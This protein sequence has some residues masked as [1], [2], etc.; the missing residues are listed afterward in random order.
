VAALVLLTACGSGAA[1]GPAG[2]VITVRTAPALAR[3]LVAPALQKGLIQL[4][5]EYSG[6]ALEFASLGQAKGTSD[7]EA[8]HRAMV[9]TLVPKRS[10]R[11]CPGP[12]AG[13]Q[14]PSS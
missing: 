7:I 4:V 10:R 8:T 3:E 13:R 9:D 11:L 1:P 6:S 2:G 14:C 12:G 5:P